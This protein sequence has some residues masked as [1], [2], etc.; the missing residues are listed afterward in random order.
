M[1]PRGCR[2]FK[3]PSRVHTSEDDSNTVRTQF[4]EHLES[5]PVLEVG[6][7]SDVEVMKVGIDWTK[8]SLGVGL[9]SHLVL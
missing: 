5:L 4:L 3:P 8:F 7:D 1:L 6:S 2:T 9:I